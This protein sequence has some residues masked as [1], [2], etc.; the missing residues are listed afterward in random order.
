MERP[1]KDSVI[2]DNVTIGDGAT[3]YRTI[4]ADGVTVPSGGHF[5][6]VAIVNA[7]MVR[8]LR[9]NSRKGA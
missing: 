4:V 8:K 2:W 7:D 1:P 5:E 9:R 3:I 6:N